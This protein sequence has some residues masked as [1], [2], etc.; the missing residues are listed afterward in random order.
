MADQNLFEILAKS[1]RQ[2]ADAAETLENRRSPTPA[3]AAESS[4][5][6]ADSEK[7]DLFERGV[8]IA[9]SLAPFA[10]SATESTLNSVVGIAENLVPL[11]KNA[12]FPFSASAESPDASEKSNQNKSQTEDEVEPA[13]PAPPQIPE[14][15]GPEVLRARDLVLYRDGLVKG[16]RVV[17]YRSATRVLLKSKV[18]VSPREPEYRGLSVGDGVEAGLELGRAVNL[19]PGAEI[20]GKVAGAAL[21]G[22]IATLAKIA[23]T[24]EDH[25]QIWLETDDSAKPLLLYSEKTQNFAAAN[26]VVTSL[27]DEI[28]KAKKEPKILLDGKKIKRKYGFCG[29]YFYRRKTFFKIKRSVRQKLLSR[30]LLNSR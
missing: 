4:E 11:A 16:N 21:G 14:S 12:G 20:V 25:C 23:P 28:E 30:V 10:A 6:N 2:V 3:E 5:P 18:S 17:H 9:K 27:C 29:L 19:T 8:E 13:P 7:N 22:A 1:A 24:P 15:F 26:A